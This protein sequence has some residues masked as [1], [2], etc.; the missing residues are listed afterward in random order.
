MSRAPLRVA[1]ICDFVEERWPS[2]DLFGEMIL[3]HL[4]SEHA[5]A[6]AVTRICPPLR[7]RLARWSPLHMHRMAWNAD[8]LVNRF[9][10]YPRVLGRLA[11]TGDFDLFHIVDHSYGQL[12]HVLPPGKTV[13]T[14]HDLDAFRS[15]LEPASE[16]RPRWFRAMAR[17]VLSGFQKAAVVICNSQTTRLAILGYKLIPES[18]LRTAHAGIS[19]EFTAE[20]NPDADFRAARLLGPVNPQGTPEL[21]HVGSN[22]PRKRIDV[23]LETFAAIHRALPAARLVKVGG[24][25]AP[26]QNQQAEAL[27]ITDRI[28]VVPSLD[29]ATLAAV[30]RR[31]SL[32][33]QPSA[34]EGFGLPVAE[35]LACGAQVLASD[36]AALREVGGEV[37]TYC[38]VGDLPAWTKAALT[39]LE[40]RRGEAGGWLARRAAG[41]ERASLF[42]WSAHA[43]KLVEIYSSLVE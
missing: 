12:A 34:A 33:L 13:I 7:S 30:Y 1:L 26:G 35:A 40:E 18:R 42:T 15:L 27:G 31:A 6:V 25:L 38:P 23:L 2:M 28:S 37:A 21:L 9:W 32:V 14:C 29:R 4:Q 39:L 20:A 43:R 19:P 17:R 8:R 22:I 24:A 16:P 36:I 3:A 5:G 11:R 10:D 41:I